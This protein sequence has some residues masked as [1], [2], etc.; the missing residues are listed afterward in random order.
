VPIS[1]IWKSSAHSSHSQSHS[2]KFKAV[3]SDKVYYIHLT[4]FFVFAVRACAVCV[5]GY[6]MGSACSNSS[7]EP[8]VALLDRQRKRRVATF[9]SQP[10]VK[11]CKCLTHEAQLQNFVSI[12]SAVTREY[13]HAS[14]VGLIPNNEYVLRELFTPVRSVDQM[15][16]ALMYLHDDID[17]LRLGDGAIMNE[18]QHGSLLSD[19]FVI[20][21]CV[22]VHKAH[23][24]KLARLRHVNGTFF[25][26][27]GL[28]MPHLEELHITEMKQI[29]TAALAAFKS[30]SIRHIEIVACSSITASC[31]QSLIRNCPH[32]ESLHVGGMEIGEPHLLARLRSRCL[33][34]FRLEYCKNP[35]DGVLKDLFLRMPKLVNLSLRG[36]GVFDDHMR[37]LLRSSK[38]GRLPFAFVAG[39]SQAFGEKAGEDASSCSS[40]YRVVHNRIYDQNV[41]HIIGQFLSYPRLRCLDLSQNSH[42]IG[43]FL[44]ELAQT[45]P[46]LEGL[47]LSN[48]SITDHTLTRMPDQLRRLDLSGCQRVRGRSLENIAAQCGSIEHLDLAGSSVVEENLYHLVMP[49]L[50]EINV[51]KCEHVDAHAVV[52]ELRDNAPALQHMT[53]AGALSIWE[54]PH[55]NH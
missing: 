42:L 20:G 50:R 36:S 6:N 21:A 51:A 32:L 11:E 49:N 4:A 34:T 1:R 33:R 38:A 28:A 41:L 9:L 19:A 17:E 27:L 25:P 10:A 29:S 3:I 45:C 54:D 24:L 26:A 15:K 8:L 2:F 47:R 18:V 43:N 14:V 52:S 53:A 48:T 16:L 40:L 7:R 22:R 5:F 37:E 13:A 23:T 12:A 44:P 30:D 35:L 46:N 55:H 31:L 39:V